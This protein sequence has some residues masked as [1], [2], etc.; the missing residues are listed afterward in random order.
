MLYESS[1]AELLSI[2]GCDVLGRWRTGA[3]SALVTE[4][5]SDREAVSFGLLGAGKQAFTQ[6]GL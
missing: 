1:S 5:L 2:M 4:Y 6:L 3:I